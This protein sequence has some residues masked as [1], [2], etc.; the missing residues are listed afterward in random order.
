MREAGEKWERELERWVTPYL[1]AFEHKVRRRWAPVYLRGLLLPGE[2]KSIEPIVN[3]VAPDEKEQIHHFVA[4]SKWDTA[5]IEAVHADRCNELVGGPDAHLI[6][7]DTGAAEERRALRRGRAS[8]LRRARQ[9]G[10]LSVSRLTH[11]RARRRSHPDRSASL[12]ARELGIGSRETGEGVRSRRHLVSPEVAHRARRDRPPLGASHS[13]RRC[14][15]RCRIRVVR[16]VS[17]GAHEEGVALDRGHSIDADRVYRV[18]PSPTANPEDSERTNAEERDP[19]RGESFGREAH[20]K[21]RPQ[22]GPKRDLA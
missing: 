20:R 16:R 11:A 5:P 2:R 7:D 19:N 13:V 17:R 22:R 10:E 15:R 12:P 6:I 21:T 14:S 9:A 3:R 8:I 1:D 18:R 4:T